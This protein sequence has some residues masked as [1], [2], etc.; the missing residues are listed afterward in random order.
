ME[1]DPSNWII[2]NSVAYVAQQAWLQNATIRDNILFDLP[3][4]ESRYK[5]VVK[6]C[7]LEKD[8]QIFEDGD[9]TE[10]GEKGIT[11]SGGQKQRCSLAR[12][13]Q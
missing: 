2:E 8:F 10:I 5:Q 6:M 9:M 7:A 11:L 13:Q 1:L 4:N 12:Y 3:Y